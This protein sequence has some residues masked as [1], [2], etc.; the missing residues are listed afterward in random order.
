MSLSVEA[1]CSLAE[2]SVADR[3]QAIS[4][5]GLRPEEQWNAL[6]RVVTCDSSPEEHAEYT[7]ALLDFARDA[8]TEAPILVRAAALDKAME[9]IDFDVRFRPE[10]AALLNTTTLD[11]YK[12]TKQIV[13]EFFKG[14]PWQL[15]Y[16]APVVQSRTVDCAYSERSL[17]FGAIRRLAVD[18][19][20]NA[21]EMFTPSDDTDFGA[22]LYDAPCLAFYL[23]KTLWRWLSLGRAICPRNV[24]RRRSSMP[25]LPG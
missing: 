4:S 20:A 22:P 15:G 6:Q 17:Y 14:K 16:K 8:T 12:A 7:A 2:V 25:V 3:V 18:E 13:P 5:A 1:Q 9:R 10:H 21:D 23:M 24:L 11:D 19:G